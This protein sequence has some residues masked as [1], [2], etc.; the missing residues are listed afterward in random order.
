MATKKRDLDPSGDDLV[1]I[2]WGVWCKNKGIS[3]D[4]GRRLRKAGK[5]PRITQI[6]ERRFGVTT[7]DDREWTL[8]RQGAR[9]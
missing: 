6:S 5:A 1:L 9:R 4:T 3:L 7:A 2:P 8:A